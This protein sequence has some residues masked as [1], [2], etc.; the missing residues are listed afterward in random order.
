MN[1]ITFETDGTGHCLYNEIVDLQQIGA[2]SMKR[3]STI[4]FNDTTQ[5][6]EVREPGGDLLFHHPSRVICLA[7]EHQHFNQ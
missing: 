4:E 3:A 1:T 6:W 2:L 7:W 5:Q